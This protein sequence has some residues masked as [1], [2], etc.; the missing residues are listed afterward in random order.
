MHGEENACS[1][2][3][4]K[5][6]GNGMCWKSHQHWLKHIMSIIIPYSSCMGKKTHDDMVI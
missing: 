2:G 5:S 3:Y 6:K 1:H 4:I